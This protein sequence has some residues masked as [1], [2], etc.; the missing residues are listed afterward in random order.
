M[1]VLYSKNFHPNSKVRVQTDITV[2]TVPMGPNKQ[3]FANCNKGH[4]LNLLQLLCI[5]DKIEA[6]FQHLI[7]VSNIKKPTSLD[8]AAKNILFPSEYSTAR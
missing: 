2:S 1:G 8:Q 6:E 4:V 3:I 7:W 5:C